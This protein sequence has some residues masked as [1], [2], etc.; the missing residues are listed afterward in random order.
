VS[1]PTSTLYDEAVAVAVKVSRIEDEA[2]TLLDDVAALVAELSEVGMPAETRDLLNAVKGRVT[3]I[4]RDFTKALGDA[5]DLTYGLDDLQHDADVRE[6]F[7][8]MALDVERGI[9]D[10][11]E[12]RA[13]VASLTPNYV[14]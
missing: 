5:E 1:N 6:D 11:S 9:A 10:P 8:R 4:A 2:D 7:A 14:L 3:D 12:L 13:L